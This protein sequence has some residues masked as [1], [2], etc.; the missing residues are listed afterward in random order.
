MR[1]Y[2][3]HW[4][5]LYSLGPSVS[6]IQPL[7]LC[8]GWNRTLGLL[9]IFLWHANEYAPS[10]GACFISRNCQQ[11]CGQGLENIHSVYWKMVVK[12]LLTLTRVSIHCL[13]YWRNTCGHS[14]LHDFI[15]PC[16]LKISDMI[17]SCIAN[18]K[19]NVTIFI[20]IAKAFVTTHFYGLTQSRSYVKVPTYTHVYWIDPLCAYFFRN[21]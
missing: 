3:H 1:L 17:F 16:S 15:H 4:A 13:E 20:F 11:H 19:S 18:E 7:R 21:I 10:S 14:A 5:L 9:L 8:L 2:Q 6:D 12:V